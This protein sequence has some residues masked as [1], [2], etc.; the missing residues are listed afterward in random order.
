MT[1]EEL[2]AERK[3]Q[4]DYFGGYAGKCFKNETNSF[5]LKQIRV[6]NGYFDYETIS[7]NKESFDGYGIQKHHWY[8]CHC[9]R[10]TGIT[11]IS[12]REYNIA[13]KRFLRMKALQ[14]VTV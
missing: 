11:K 5:Y 10:Y 14:I 7:F 2:K 12:R 13:K 3:H 4:D 1:K 8:L 9:P 6:W